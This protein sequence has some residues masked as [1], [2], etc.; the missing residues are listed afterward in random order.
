[1]IARQFGMCPI[2]AAEI[3]GPCHRISASASS[4][5]GG[6]GSS[7]PSHTVES[8]ATF[9][10]KGVSTLAVLSVKVNSPGQTITTLAFRELIGWI[11]SFP[12]RSKV[13]DL[14][15]TGAKRWGVSEQLHERV[16]LHQC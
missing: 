13:V 12:K 15:R 11:T 4:T 8:S 9:S 16:A 10:S 14:A 6:R 5:A 7:N 3:F 2:S 1:M